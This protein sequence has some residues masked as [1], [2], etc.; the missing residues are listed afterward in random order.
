LQIERRAYYRIDK[1]EKHGEDF[2]FSLIL[3]PDGKAVGLASIQKDTD[4]K[5]DIVK[6]NLSEK[7]EEKKNKASKKEKKEKKEV[8][9]GEKL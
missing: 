2:D 3:V 6:Q 1:V 5:G 9:A 4:K 8:P 7:Q